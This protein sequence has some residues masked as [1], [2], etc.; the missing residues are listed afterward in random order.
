VVLLKICK[1]P[2]SVNRGA[3]VSTAVFLVAVF[4][5]VILTVGSP[6]MLLRIAATRFCVLPPW[7]FLLASS[8]FY[9]VCGAAL[10]AVLF[11]R[12]RGG[13]T[14]KYRGAFFVSVAVSAS[15][16]WYA[17]TFGAHF[18][19]PAFLL[20]VVALFGF[21]VAAVNFRRV[22]RLASVG[23][24]CVVAWS[25]YFAVLTLLLFFFV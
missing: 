2:C 17:V 20:S 8:V 18:F 24:C 5:A 7:L 21:F 25:A 14:A 10:G 19:L 4:W 22:C 13:E 6:R 11:S 1:R 16:L 9:A 12:G 3:V 23:M 15:Y